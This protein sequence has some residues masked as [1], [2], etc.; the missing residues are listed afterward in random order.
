MS[1]LHLYAAVGAA[2]ADTPCKF[3]HSPRDYAP[4]CCTPDIAK[5]RVSLAGTCGD[6]QLDTATSVKPRHHKHVFDL[7][8][9]SCFDVT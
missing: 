7:L 1:V 3:C 8:Q 9:E 6:M 2:C 5:Q 4:V